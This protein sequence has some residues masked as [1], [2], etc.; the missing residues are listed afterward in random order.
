M[1]GINF[2]AFIDTLDKCGYAYDK[3]MRVENLNTLETGF[4]YV[5]SEHKH[6]ALPFET[7][8]ESLLKVANDKSKVKFGTACYK[9]APEITFHTVIIID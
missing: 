8:K 9:Y 7:L 5:V 6:P 1:C 3:F 4:R 2:Q